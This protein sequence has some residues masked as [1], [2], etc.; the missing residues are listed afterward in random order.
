MSMLAETR[1]KPACIEVHTGIHGDARTSS[2]GGGWSVVERPFRCLTGCSRPTISL[3]TLRIHKRKTEETEEQARIKLPLPKGTAPGRNKQMNKKTR[4]SAATATA[5]TRTT[6]FTI[7][8]GRRK[9][10]PTSRTLSRSSMSL[11]LNVRTV[12][13]D[14]L[15]PNCTFSSTPCFSEEFARTRGAGCARHVTRAFEAIK[16]IPSSLCRIR[17]HPSRHLDTA[18]WCRRDTQDKTNATAVY[19]MAAAVRQ[20]PRA[21]RTAPKVGRSTS[22]PTPRPPPLRA[23]GEPDGV[24]VLLQ[25]RH[26]PEVRIDA[27]HA[28]RHAQ[29]PPIL[30]AGLRLVSFPLPHPSPGRLW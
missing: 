11:C 16:P 4:K 27:T 29:P 14:R 10:L 26:M 5:P 7:R 19:D 25:M 24:G 22:P 21:A 23:G 1:T 8:S 2:H 28:V 18:V 30:P 9:G 17:C 13:R 6:G 12:L 20:P 15:M 3:G